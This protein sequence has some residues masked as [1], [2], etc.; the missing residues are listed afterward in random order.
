MESPKFRSIKFY[1]DHF[2]K[3]KSFVKDL[4][5]FVN[6]QYG[7]RGEVKLEKGYR[8]FKLGA[9]IHDARLEKGLT[10]EELAERCGTD[11]AYIS[12]VEN[13]IKDVRMST[14]QKIIEI[15]LGGKLQVSIKL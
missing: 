6:E 15:G 1:R 2:M 10:Q 9:L 13:N 12:K 5:Q 11:K 4:D 8:E 7:A 3:K 14:L